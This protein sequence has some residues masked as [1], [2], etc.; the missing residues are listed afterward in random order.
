MPTAG[1]SRGKSRA[2]AWAA[3]A[4]VFTAAV[5][6]VG[7]VAART[8]DHE[9][10]DVA[11]ALAAAVGQED[12]GGSVRLADVARFPWSDVYVFGPYAEVSR[13]GDT[14]GIPWSPCS[15]LSQLV[16]CDLMLSSE[17]EYLLVFV[18]RETSSVT[19]WT[20]TVPSNPALVFTARG[21]RVDSKL[22]RE[23]ACFRV[24]EFA[25]HL[26]LDIAYVELVGCPS[27]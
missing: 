20:D 16:G 14:L 11:H 17:D 7:I 23:D 5:V 19:G 10:P 24:V 3:A 15:R 8:P 1:H 4:T 9:R 22:P 6:L 25:H 26:D 21:G 12:V 13:I 18:D 27:P 2:L